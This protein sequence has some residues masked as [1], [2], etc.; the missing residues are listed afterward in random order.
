MLWFIF[1]ILVDKLEIGFPSVHPRK[2]SISPLPVKCHERQGG[3]ELKCRKKPSAGYLP[4]AFPVKEPVS[5]LFEFLRDGLGFFMSLK[6]RLVLLV[7][8][9]ALTL[10]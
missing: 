10:E 9:P 4:C 8:S 6:P 7:K 3:S 1:Q 2:K 5:S